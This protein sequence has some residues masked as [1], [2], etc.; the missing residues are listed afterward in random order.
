MKIV[1]AFE[2]FYDGVSD[3]KKSII[4]N[5]ELEV[6]ADCIKKYKQ[7]MLHSRIGGMKAHICDL[8]IEPYVKNLSAKEYIAI[9]PHVLG[10]GG[11]LYYYV[12]YYNSVLGYRENI[13]DYDR[14]TKYYKNDTM[15][16]S[17]NMSITGQTIDYCKIQFKCVNFDMHICDSDNLVLVKE[18]HLESIIGKNFLTPEHVYYTIESFLEHSVENNAKYKALGQSKYYKKLKKESK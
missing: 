18:P 5:R 15:R 3:K 6:D 13:F 17:F 2:D 10:I 11:K 14:L 8:N 12:E 16:R 9:T 4:Y 7:G 1:S